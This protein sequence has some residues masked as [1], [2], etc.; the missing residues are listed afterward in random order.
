ML[1]LYMYNKKKTKEGF[2]G[3]F[4]KIGKFAEIKGVSQNL[5]HKIMK[6]R[7]LCL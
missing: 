7:L 4:L 1:P 6:K 3:D 5:E 2:S